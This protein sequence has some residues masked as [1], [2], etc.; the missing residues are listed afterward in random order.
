MELFIEPRDTG[1]K[2]FGG[3]HGGRRL[4]QEGDARLHFRDGELETLR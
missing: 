4:R 3:A 1:S 2:I